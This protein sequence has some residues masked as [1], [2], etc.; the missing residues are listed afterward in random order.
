[1]ADATRQA[2]EE[3]ANA[4]DDQDLEPTPKRVSVSTLRYGQ[5]AR[6]YLDA[7]EKSV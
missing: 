4:A 5:R 2:Q 6:C 7:W 1:M 3:E